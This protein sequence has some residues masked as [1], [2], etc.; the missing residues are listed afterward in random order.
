MPTWPTHK[1]RAAIR[2]KK[3]NSKRKTKPIQNDQPTYY[4]RANGG[5][6]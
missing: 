2:R 4:G 5:N 3:R 6:P 1:R